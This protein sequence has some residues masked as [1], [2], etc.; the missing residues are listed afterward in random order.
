MNYIRLADYNNSVQAQLAKLALDD[1]QIPCRVS[2]SD[3]LQSTL[4]S[5][6]LFVVAAKAAE[7]RAV[8]RSLESTSSKPARREHSDSSD[9]CVR[10]AF[11]IALAA[12]FILP[13]PLHL[14]SLWVLFGARW[15][16]LGASSRTLYRLTILIDSLVLGAIGW[17]VARVV[18]L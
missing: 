1:A 13:G 2:D 11:R 7:A 9:V 3:V 8:L 14:Y 6:S 12:L 18:S 4:G 15:G 17:F 16:A 10:R 5:V